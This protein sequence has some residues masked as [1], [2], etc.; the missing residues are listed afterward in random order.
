M[1]SLKKLTEAIDI[2]NSYTGN[3][4][5]I[6]MLK[7][8]YET[9]KKLDIIGDFQVE[10]ILKNKDFIPKPINKITKLADW[11]AEKKKQDWELDF[12]PVK[13]KIIELLGET[14]T[15]YHC[16]V[17]YRQSVDPVMCFLPKKA[18]LKN[19]LVEDYRNLNI[20]FNRY[21]RISSEK[22]NGRKLLEHQKDGVKF[23]LSR[24]KCILAD[25][26]G[27]GKMEPVDSLIPTPKGFVK[28]GDIN[29]NDIVFDQYGKPTIVLKTFLHKDKDIYKIFFNDGTSCECGLEHLWKVSEENENWEVLSLEEIM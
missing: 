20:D 16:Y 27:T 3:N 13:I 15:T 2:L 18:I 8:N 12:L 28:M 24:R 21:D 29:E 4:P 5:Y 23:L 10:Y 11:Y 9:I 25:D 14:S 19:F 6:L 7:R 26:Q 22:D 17:K 1:S